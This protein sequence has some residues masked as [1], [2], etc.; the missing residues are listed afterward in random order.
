M[1]LHGSLWV[2]MTADFGPMALVA[3]GACGV[4][5]RLNIFFTIHGL[6]DTTEIII[7]Q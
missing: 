2:F 1:G 7:F 5:G 6:N 4:L 3:D